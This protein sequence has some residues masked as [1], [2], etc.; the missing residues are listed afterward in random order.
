MIVTETSLPGVLLIEPK[1]FADDRG[2]FMETYNS[3]RF[4]EAGMEMPF[5]QDNHSRSRRGVLRGLHYQE[6]NPQGKLV[7]CIRGEL[8]DVAVDIRVGSPHFGK[9]FGTELTE[10]NRLMLWVPPGFAH[11]F[12]A[13]SD[14]TDL[15]YKCTE[16]YDGAADRSIAWDDPD[17]GITWPLSSPLLSAKDAAAPRLKDAPVLPAYPLPC[18]RKG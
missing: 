9:W 16:L 12:C 15:A 7:R 10:E 11:G 2:F 17:I 6:P 13:L 3:A 4:S 14:W 18:D 8:W 5:V 1:L